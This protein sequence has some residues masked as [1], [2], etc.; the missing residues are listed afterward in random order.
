MLQG[1]LSHSK[2]RQRLVIQSAVVLGLFITGA[3]AEFFHSV[4]TQHIRCAD[5]GEMVH[6]EGAAE[7]AAERVEHRH[8]HLRGQPTAAVSDGH[9]HCQNS[10]LL[11]KKYIAGK[12]ATH[13]ARGPQCVTDPTPNL[14]HTAPTRDQRLRSAPKNS[15]PV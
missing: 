7:G 3:S 1:A 13:L 5:H 12:T 6:L 8:S 9:E 15:P 4:T 14:V 11:R 10:V 2:Y